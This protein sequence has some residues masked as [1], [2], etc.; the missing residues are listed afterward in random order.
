MNELVI[1]G[2]TVVDGTGAP[3]PGATS[4]S[5]DGRITEIGDDVS[6]GDAGARRR[7]PRRRPR[8][9]RHPH[10][11]R[12]PGVLGPGAHP[13]VLPRRH[14]RRRRQL[15]LLDR[16]DPCRAPRPDRPHARERRGHGR[17]HARRRAS[18]GTIRDLPR[19]P[20]R[21]RAQRAW[22]ST[23]RRYVG[24]TALR[25]FVMGDDA[26]ERAA[27]ADEIARDAAD[28]RARRSTPAPP[29]SPPA[30]RPPTAAPTA[31]PCRA[32]SPS[33][34]RSTALL[35]TVA[36]SRPRRRRVHARRADAASTT[37]YDLQPRIGVPFTYTALLTTPSLRPPAHDG[38]QPQGLGRRRP[39]LA[40][41]VAAAARFTMS[42]VEPFTLN[43][44]PVFGE[45]MRHRSTPAATPTSD[46]A[47]RARRR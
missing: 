3:G 44:N 10:A 42:M 31:S 27:T 13:V 29:A 39:G 17:R 9:H 2:G 33:A 24:H 36:E 28:R 14:D 43:A 18:R 45:L 5:S 22:A 12:R 4:P 47:W 40:A 23:S 38:G 20:R 46:P 34:P 6:T 25:L 30:S 8:L 1:R 35:A 7:R 32:A 41:G 11:L 26:Y 21:G 37:L 16:A 15:R 19:V